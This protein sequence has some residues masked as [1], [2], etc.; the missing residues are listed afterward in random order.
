MKIRTVLSIALACAAISAEAVAV[1]K[2]P[3]VTVV[4]SETL[5]VDSMKATSVRSSNATVF[6]VALREA[7]EAV[8]NGL[9]LG[10]ANLVYVDGRG[11]FATRPVTVV[12]GYWDVLKRMF[13]DDP[14]ITID[15]VGDKVVVGG[16]TA[17]VDT[18]KRVDQARA[19][20]PSRIVVQVSYSTAQIGELVRD[21]LSRAAIS[22]IA[23]NVVG[24]EVCLSGRMYDQKSIAQLKAR[25]DGFVKDYP[26]VTVNTDDL[27]I[28]KQKILISIEFVQYNDTLAR[29]LGFK[30]PESVTATLKSSNIGYN[31]NTMHGNDESHEWKRDFTVDFNAEA[32]VNMLKKNGVAKTFYATTLSTQSGIEVEFQNGGTY[33]ER[34]D[35][36]LTSSGGISEIEYGY[37]IKATP[38]ILDDST[39]N[40]DLSLDNKQPTTEAGRVDRVARYQTKSKYLMRPGESIAL[41]GFTAKSEG[42]TKNGTPFLSK[43][44]LIGSWLFGNTDRSNEMKEMMLVVTVNWSLESMEDTALERLEEIKSRPVEVETP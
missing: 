29:N 8:V 19:L 37:I 3:S 22:N 4:E 13:Y 14:E 10:E 1:R 12:P 24:H 9:R 32:T 2:L 27:R 21:F 38:F 23:V 30:G 16:A 25:V 41:S 44:P 20:D 34:T 36:G 6:S 26:G 43:I 42:E 5:S 31:R 17:N 15:I 7:G 33:Y 28:Y 35:A 18:L 39:I 40:L 11:A